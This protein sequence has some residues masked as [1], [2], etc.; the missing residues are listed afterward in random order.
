MARSRAVGLALVLVIAV[1]GGGLIWLGRGRS[2]GPPHPK[3]WDARIVPLVHFVE[4]NRGLRFRH[5]V[6]VDYLSD[7]D[8]RRTVANENT[9]SPEQ[10][11]DDEAAARALG[12]PVGKNGLAAAG[13]TLSGEGITAY[14]DD[15]TGRIDV[16]GTDLTVGRRATIVHELTHALQDQHFDISRQGSYS[17]DDRNAAFEAV[18][19]GDAARL[20]DAY[21]DSLPKRDQDA[22]DAEE[23]ASNAAYDA[24]IKDVPDWLS[25]TSDFPYS[26]GESFTQAVAADGGPAAV[27]RALKAPPPAVAEIMQPAR[28]LRGDHPR[29]VQAPA[30]PPGDRVAKRNDLGALKW[31][32]LL[33]ERIPAADALRAADAW[34]GDAYVAYEDA[35][36]ICVKAD[37]DGAAPG[38]DDGL[39]TALTAWAR[40]MPAASGASVSHRG[41][42]VELA[43]CDP[44]PAAFPGGAVK[45]SH[46]DEAV[47]LLTDRAA[48]AVSARGG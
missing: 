40:A 37:V 24:G 38:A 47:K 21:V 27:D 17:S 3:Q 36:R 4:Q 7:E 23:A 33:A 5:P 22:Y 2:S 39:A 34:G 20:E 15:A 14:Y 30:A 9:E 43:S 35:G 41:G 25:A 10:Q 32:L 46:V 31:L 13:S 11:R 42:V 48:A 18:V 12:L 8:F 1:A 28:Y 44:G 45:G 26:I 6:A 29:T 19:E 16:R